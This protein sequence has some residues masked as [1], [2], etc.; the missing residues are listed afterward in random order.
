MLLS[1][2]FIPSLT[3]TF[4]IGISVWPPTMSW[5]SALPNFV[6]AKGKPFGICT[7]PFTVPLAPMPR[8]R[9]FLPRFHTRTAE[10][11]Q[12]EGGFQSEHVEVFA[13]QIDRQFL[14]ADEIDALVGCAFIVP[15]LSGK[16]EGI[17]EAV[18]KL[19][20]LAKSH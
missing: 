16:F 14:R 6:P 20:V 12:L 19:S 2:C 1:A 13:R 11:A 10:S 17:A 4:L 7:L 15:L 5:I 9:C 18:N 3:L 8:Y